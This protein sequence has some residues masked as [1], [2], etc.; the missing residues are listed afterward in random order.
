MHETGAKA[1][2]YCCLL[3]LL[4]LTNGGEE[5]T[6][7]LYANSIH[8]DVL[9]ASLVRHSFPCKTPL[10]GTFLTVSAKA[11]FSSFRLVSRILYIL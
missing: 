7:R 1:Y 10:P 5:E 11:F 2:N 8:S 4:L 6:E 9:S 3:L